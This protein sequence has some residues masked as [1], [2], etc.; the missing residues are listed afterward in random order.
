VP[1]AVSHEKS[2]PPEIRGESPFNDAVVMGCSVPTTGL[3]KALVPDTF[4]SQKHCVVMGASA[5]KKPP[6]VLTL[7]KL[8]AA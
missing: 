1:F 8:T 4:S 7:E 5:A 2:Q 6:T 3:T